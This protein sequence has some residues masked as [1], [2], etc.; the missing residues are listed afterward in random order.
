MAKKKEKKGKRRRVETM[1]DAPAAKRER[2]DVEDVE[3]PSG[4]G[5]SL[6][7]TK[8]SN[9]PP[10]LAHDD[11]EV[12]VH[13]LTRYILIIAGLTGLAMLVAW[14]LDQGFTASERAAHTPPL[15]MA[16]AQPTAPREPRLQRLPRVGLQAFERAQRA[17][18]DR[19]GWVD[20]E[21]GIVQIPIERAMDLAVERGLPAR[22]EGKKPVSDVGV[23]TESSLEPGGPR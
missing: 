17:E 9:L 2:R 8:K 3:A 13:T 20:Q 12:N 22:E 6:P 21:E 19:Y 7:P 11:R 14:Y 18:L 4:A 5:H 15:P 16:T 1:P 23:P 10:E